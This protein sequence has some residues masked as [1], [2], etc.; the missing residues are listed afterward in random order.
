MC[1]S[2]RDCVLHNRETRGLLAPL[3][4]RKGLRLGAP[5]LPPSL[6]NVA[7]WLRAAPFAFVHEILKNT[8]K[9][10]MYLG[11]WVFFLNCGPPPCRAAG[12][13]AWGAAGLPRGGGRCGRPPAPAEPPPQG[14][15]HP[16]GS[17][18]PR[19]RAAAAGSPGWGVAGSKPARNTRKI[20]RDPPGR[21][22]RRRAL[23]A[24]GSPPRPAPRPAARLSL[25]YSALWR[26]IA[27]GAG[28][29]SGA[30]APSARG[31]GRREPEAQQR[32]AGAGARSRSPHRLRE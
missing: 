21:P 24:R 16:P 18:W 13:G 26:R 5:C 27:T 28:G 29:G 10:S 7:P 11:C 12:T 6:P 3:V 17:A 2:R 22:R 25:T 19:S 1:I 9:K 31:R 32:A 15:G 8:I 23:P 30:G 14:G 4:P 20:F